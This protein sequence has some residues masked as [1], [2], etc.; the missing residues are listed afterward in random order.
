[1]Q[2]ISEKFRQLF[3][4]ISWLVTGRRT[5]SVCGRIPFAQQFTIICLHKELSVKCLQPTQALTRF[6]SLDN[7]DVNQYKQTKTDGKI[8]YILHDDRVNVKFCDLPNMWE[9]VWA[10]K[11][12]RKTCFAKYSPCLMLFS[13]GICNENNRP[14]KPENQKLCFAMYVFNRLPKNGRKQL[15][16]RALCFSAETV[17]SICKWRKHDDFEETTCWKVKTS[18]FVLSTLFWGWFSHRT[19]DETTE[20]KKNT[21]FLNCCPSISGNICHT[22]WSRWTD[23][24]NLANKQWRSDRFIA[25]KSW[26]LWSDT[27]SRPRIARAI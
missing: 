12:A 13:H 27:N 5:T 11:F 10:R 8:F 2:T 15:N 9:M 18:F 6:L 20:V 4:W 24:R 1:M 21:N 19:S 16:W 7:F 23:C 17:L 22:L 3:T 14:L 25:G 26:S